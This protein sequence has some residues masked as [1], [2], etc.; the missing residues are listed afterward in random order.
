MFLI[1][2]TANKP[3]IELG[4]IVCSV[5]ASLDGQYSGNKR[6]RA[7]TVTVSSFTEQDLWKQKHELSMDV[8]LDWSQR[9]FARISIA[10]IEFLSMASAPEAT[11]VPL[12]ISSFCAMKAMSTR[13]DEPQRASRPFDT[14][15]EG[16]VMGAGT[17]ALEG[18]GVARCMKMAL[19]AP[20]NQLRKPRSALRSR[21]RADQRDRQ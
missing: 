15:R 13:N 20:A 14:Q 18:E 19:R 2:P 11:I 10:A 21:L 4:Q 8:Y 9:M 7:S 5:L 6:S 12:G 3:I 1:I 17:V 16:F